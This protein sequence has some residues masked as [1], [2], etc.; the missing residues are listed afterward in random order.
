MN[1]VI[2]IEGS[3]SYAT[4]A[5]LTRAIENYGLDELRGQKDRPLRYIVCCNAVGRYTAVFLVSEWFRVNED[6][7]Y[8]GI[9][10]QYGFMSV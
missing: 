7:G 8:L 2:T 4:E 3:R 10:S 9:A 1:N 6:G 5:N